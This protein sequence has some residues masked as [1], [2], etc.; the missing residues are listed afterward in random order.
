MQISTTKNTKSHEK[1]FYSS[2][3][4]ENLNTSS[5]VAFASS[6]SDCASNGADN[7]F[8]RIH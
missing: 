6:G 5:C 8:A 1:I 7:S 3:G 4:A 2:V